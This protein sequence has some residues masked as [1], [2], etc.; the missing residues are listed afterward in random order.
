L[1]ELGERSALDEVLAAVSVSCARTNEQEPDQVESV[2]LERKHMT[3]GPS[4]QS[5][6]GV[7]ARDTVRCGGGW[8]LP[9]RG[10]WG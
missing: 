7:Q 5:K 6:S 9:T 4:M 10:R 2:Y 8:A 3:G 1:P